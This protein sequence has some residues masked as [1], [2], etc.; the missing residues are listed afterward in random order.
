[1]IGPISWDN[2]ITRPGMLLTVQ[3]VKGEGRPICPEAAS[4]GRTFHGFV[5]YC[6]QH[7]HDRRRPEPHRSWITLATSASTT[8]DWNSRRM[9]EEER[10]FSH[11]RYFQS[12]D[13]DLRHETGTRFSKYDV[14]LRV[15]LYPKIARENL[16]K[17]Y[18]S[19]AYCVKQDNI[20][21]KLSRFEK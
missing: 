6:F 9:F 10:R 13:N 20:F 18:M 2:P 15:F 14:S 7:V 21:T 5:D 16:R 4:W 17:E 1:M 3:V 8:R 11:L 19:K 12:R